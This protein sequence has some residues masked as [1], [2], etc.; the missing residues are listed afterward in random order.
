MTNFCC[1]FCGEKML[2][3]KEI[4]KEVNPVTFVFWHEECLDNPK[5][6]IPI[7]TRK[8]YQKIGVSF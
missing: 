3:P 6:G 5:F 8:M 7:E 1:A 4:K 2:I